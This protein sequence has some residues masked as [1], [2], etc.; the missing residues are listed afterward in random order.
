ME[1]F[2]NQIGINEDY[3]TYFEESNVEEV[4]VSKETNRFHFFIKVNQPLP[5]PVY[6]DLFT[7]LKEAFHHEIKLTLISSKNTYQ[8]INPYIKEIIKEYANV[9]M[10]YNVFLDREAKIN[11]EKVE[12]P[13][14]NKIEELNL[15]NIERELINKLKEYGFANIDFN[16]ILE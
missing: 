14:Y 2:L 6:Q 7:S 3:L 11:E 12:Y 8:E 5:Y 9:S 10:R 4:K 15:K 16:I 13:V 1:V